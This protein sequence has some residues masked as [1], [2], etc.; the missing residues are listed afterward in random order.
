MN[1]FYVLV[2]ELRD[3]GIDA[4]FEDSAHSARR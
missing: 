1:S 4:R 3:H 2:N